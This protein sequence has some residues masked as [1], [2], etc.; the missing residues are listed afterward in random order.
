MKTLSLN[1]FQEKKI[2]LSDLSEIEDLPDIIQ[3]T[4]LELNN[5][6]DTMLTKVATII[7]SIISHKRKYFCF[8]RPS[9]RSLMKKNNVGFS[10]SD[11]KTLL[12]YLFSSNII[13]IEQKSKIN[14]PGIY[15]LSH[16]QILELL[17]LTREECAKQRDEC[18]DFTNKR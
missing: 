1:F 9:V 6:P 7:N 11:Y 4:I 18:F 16:P 12:K 17:N 8:S 14:T 5:S 15:K 13:S 2:I 3:N 10:D